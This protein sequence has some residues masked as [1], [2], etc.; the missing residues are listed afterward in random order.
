MSNYAAH[1]VFQL[2]LPANAMMPAGAQRE[3]G[4]SSTLTDLPCT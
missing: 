3:A 2:P 4:I 1:N